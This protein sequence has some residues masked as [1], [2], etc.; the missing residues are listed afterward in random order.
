MGTARLLTVS[1]HA[2]LGGVPAR[3]VYLPGGV[4]YLPR[5]GGVPAQGGVS[6]WGVYLP[7]A[8]LGKPRGTMAPGPVKISHK[9]DG[10]QRQPH[11]F[12][13]S[14]PPPLTRLLD[15]LLTCQG[16][17]CTCPGTPLWTEW[18]T[19]AKILPC[20]KLR[21]RAVN[22]GS[23]WRPQAFGG[24]IANH[25]WRLCLWLQGIKGYFCVCVFLWSLPSKANVK[26]EHHHL[27]P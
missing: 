11:R 3:G 24:L 4:V 17:W 27:L 8:D 13:V 18:Q 5:V 2:L 25:T 10:C 21:L 12:H 16:G 7:V 19:G 15:P 20:P 9:K 26:N 1:Q 14:R 23:R 6:A 22:I